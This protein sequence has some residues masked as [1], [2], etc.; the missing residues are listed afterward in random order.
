VWDHEQ[1]SRTWVAPSLRTYLEWWL[2]VRSRSDDTPRLAGPESYSPNRRT[3]TFAFTC[4][5]M[6]RDLSNLRA[7]AKRSADEIDATDSDCD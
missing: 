5:G 7:R 6:A 4:L 1:D 2:L 3:N